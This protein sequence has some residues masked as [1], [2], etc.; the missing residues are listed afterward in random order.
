M[1]N[2]P[3]DAL[4]ND[5]NPQDLESK[6]FFGIH[7]YGGGADE[8]YIQANKEGLLLFAFQLISAAKQTGHV[9][10]SP[11][12]N[13]IPLDYEAEWIDQDSNTFI[14][15]IE[16]IAQRP[17]GESIKPKK[18]TFLDKLIPAGCIVAAIILVA[19]TLVGLWTLAKWIF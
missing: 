4:I 2:D 13:V 3:I 11:T 16:P 6:A 12:K 7:Q 10:L 5:L 1:T 19:A 17:I 9:L 8:S 18:E 15:Y 14:Q